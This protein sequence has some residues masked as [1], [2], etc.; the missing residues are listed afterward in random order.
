MPGSVRV[1]LCLTEGSPHF[2]DGVRA[3]S[4]QEPAGVPNGTGYNVQFNNHHW[5][6]VFYRTVC[7]VCPPLSLSLS[8]GADLRCRGLQIVTHPMMSILIKPALYTPGSSATSSQIVVV[9]LAV[10]TA[11][12]VPWL[13]FLRT[14]LSKC[15]FLAS[16]INFWRFTPGEHSST[17]AASHFCRKPPL[18]HLNNAFTPHLTL[19]SMLPISNRKLSSDFSFKK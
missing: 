9:I 19:H 1:R 18:S 14:S 17:A 8:P 7:H 15:L 5:A 4:C 6:N 3:D 2:R 12:L 13:G 10:S 11:R 16:R